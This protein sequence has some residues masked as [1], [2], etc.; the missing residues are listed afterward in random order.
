MNWDS[1]IKKLVSQGLPIIASSLGG[2]ASIAVATATAIADQLGVDPTPEQITKA[3][4]EDPDAL[5]KL[6]Q[7]E[8]Q[9]F[10]EAAATQ[11]EAIVADPAD[12]QRLR[13]AAA[14]R[15]S[16][17]TM[18]D[19]VRTFLALILVPSPLV[20]LVLWGMGKIDLSVKDAVMLGMLIG[21][22]LGEAKGASQF[23]FGTSL[24]SKKKSVELAEKD[25]R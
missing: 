9:M 24:G 8:R 19:Y 17:P 6:K 18:D 14:A 4:V 1:L 3:I 12:V 5:T 22:M 20:I 7:L 16:K 10:S 15:A 11:E 21:Y 23:Y 2:P 25:P 13:D